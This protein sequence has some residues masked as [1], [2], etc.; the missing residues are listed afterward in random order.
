VKIYKYNG[1]CN[2]S[3][4]TIRR[5]RERN[6]LSQEQLAAKLQCVDCNLVQKSIS[7]IE[8]GDR[9]VADFE[10]LAFAKVF[11]VP[12]EQLFYPPPLNVSV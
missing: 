12:L 4:E 10:L 6:K 1:K 8:T 5:L 11:D 9:L 3:G 7:R 2:A